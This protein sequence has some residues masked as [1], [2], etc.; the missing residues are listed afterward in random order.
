MKPNIR[1]LVIAIVAAIVVIAALALLQNNTPGTKTL[2]VFAA[3]SLTD[4]LTE[5]GTLFEAENPNL[6]IQFNFAASSTLSAQINSGATADLFAS[7]NPNQMN[8]A[9]ESGRIDPEKVAPFTQNQLAVIFPKENPA[10]IT[11][12]EDL[13]R[14]GIL[15]LLVVP[16]APVRDYT[17]EVLMMSGQG[18]H[19]AVLANLTSEEANVRQLVAKIALGEADAGIT[20]TSD[21]TPDQAET[22]GMIPIPQSLNLDISY[23]IAP[24]KDSA[25]PEVTADFIALIL[26]P[27]GQAVLEKWGFI[28]LE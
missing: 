28:P 11:S 15:L 26:S 24:L 21:V 4:A 5:I 12:L 20:Y 19:D 1:I 10:G 3:S 8:T 7:A 9:A 27:A 13:A 23:V 17:E 22:V 6:E 2:T 18:F 16:G 14:P 25:E